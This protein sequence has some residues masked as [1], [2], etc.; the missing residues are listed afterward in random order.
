MHTSNMGLGYKDVTLVS[1]EI[2]T[3]PTRDIIKNSIKVDL[4]PGIV[5]QTPIIAAPMKDVCD[6]NVAKQMRT[7]GGIGI[8]HRFCS[9]EEQ[10]KEFK[11]GGEC[12]C[13]VGLD[14]KKRIEFLYR[15]GCRYFC[16]DTANAANI[17]VKKYIE[18]CNQVWNDIY[19]MVGNVVSKEGYEWCQS[20]PNVKCIRTGVS[21]GLACSTKSSTGIFHPPVS[22]IQECTKVKKDS[23]MVVDGGISLQQDLCKSLIFGGDCAIFGSLIASTSDSP[24]EIVERDGKFFKVLHGSASFDIQK[25]YKNKPKY[26]EGKTVLIPYKEESLEE[27]V[28]RFMDGLISSMSYFNA[29]TLEQY[30]ENLNYLIQN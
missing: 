16:L 28:T 23:C 3:I 15:E 8:L 17:R 5:L 24:A 13:A 6:S 19:W 25:I 12:I 18:F 7:L 27:L 22:L 20:I 4:F 9:V 1:R 10:V 26:I 2:S 29:V 21:G 11:L 30:R 14:D